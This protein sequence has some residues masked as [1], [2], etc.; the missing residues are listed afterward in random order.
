MSNANGIEVAQKQY[1]LVRIITAKNDDMSTI[2]LVLSPFVH[3]ASAIVTVT[4]FKNG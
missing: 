3:V 1:E 2:F 4:E